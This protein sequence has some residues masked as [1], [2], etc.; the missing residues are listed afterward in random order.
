MA[1]CLTQPK[2]IRNPDELQ[3]FRESGEKCAVLGS[4]REVKSNA[5][6]EALVGRWRDDSLPGAR[7]DGL[8]IGLAI[9]G[10]GMRGAVSAGATAAIHYLG[11]AESFDCVYGSSAGSM[12]GSYFVSRQLGGISVYHAILPSAAKDFID[13]RKLISTLGAPNR[14]ASR[15]DVFNLNFLLEKVMS[16]CQKFDYETFLKNNAKQPLSIMTS[17]LETLQ[18]VR[19]SSENGNFDDLPTLLKCIRSSMLVPGVTGELMALYEGE[20]TP[21]IV[22]YPKRK[23]RLRPLRSGRR[24]RRR[25]PVTNLLGDALITEPI[26]YRQAVK[27]GCSHV[28]V[29]RT[30][31]D[32]ALTVLHGK[33]GVYERVIA[34]RCLERY[35]HHEAAAYMM[36]QGHVYTYAEDLLV[37]GRRSTA[38][39]AGLDTA[40]LLGIAPAQGCKEVGQLEMGRA[41]ILTGM[42]DGA[43]QVLDEFGPAMGIPSDSLGWMLEE[44]LPWH[45]SMERSTTHAEFCNTE[46]IEAGHEYE[47]MPRETRE[48]RGE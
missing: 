12:I 20:K 10:G 33:G 17:D 40:H 46:V 36:K 8:K 25:A 41:P 13:K 23:R 32:P 9:E 35:G 31:P 45:A 27:D 43:R 11:L 29:L 42:R 26:P 38:H 5:V 21:C 4:G 16:E 37:L 28:L 22:E 3:R 39:M 14:F 7:N 6:R 2:L 15:N 47:P 18:A 1:L 48:Q 34:R 30:R 44:I 19:L 24:R